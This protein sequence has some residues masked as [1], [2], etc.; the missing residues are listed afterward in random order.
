MSLFLSKGELSFQKRVRKF[1]EENIAPITEKV[2][3]EEYFPREILSKM[4]QSRLLGAPFPASDGGLGLGWSYE[5]LIAEEVSAVSAATEMARLASAALYSAPL[6]SFGTRAQKKQ[7]LAPVLAGERVGVLALTEPEA[8]SDAASIKTRARLANDEFVLDGEKRFITNGGI[9]DFLLVF[10]VTDPKQGA[11][12]GISAFVVPRESPG[13]R[14]VRHYTLLGMH[15]AKVAH[16]RFR[17]TRVPRTNLVG[18]LNQGFS[19][20][21]DELDKE[22]PAVAAGMAG[23]ARSAIEASV[24]YSAARKQFGKPIRSF[25][26]V[27]F[28]VA[29]MATKLEASRLLILKAARLLDHGRNSRKEGAMAKLF[30]TET[31]FETAHDALQVHGGIG[32]ATQQTSQ[33]NVISETRDS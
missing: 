8:G 24:R 19:V 10:A 30:A 2:E 15:G 11:R 26:A 27:S 1:A 6:S 33:S 22:R 25:E 9:A 29:D 16:L 14:V 31:S 32:Y 23:I 18:G 17:N 4:G 3:R 21:L 28:K 7:F 13:V 5:I 12:R 20:L